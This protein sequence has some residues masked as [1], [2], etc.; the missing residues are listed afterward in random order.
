MRS[1]YQTH[2]L[3]GSLLALALLTAAACGNGEGPVSPAPIDELPRPLTAEEKAVI[4]ASNAFGF[5]LLREVHAAE[6]AP[7]VVLSPLSASLALGMTMNG[8][9]SETWEA[10]RSALRFGDLEEPAI[11]ASYHG[12]LD[13]LLD[14][15]SRVTMEI[16]NS[17]W[18]REGTPFV[19]AFFDAAREWF[20]A[21]VRELRFDDPASVDVINDWASDNTAGRIDEIIERIDPDN[22]MFLLNAVYFKGQWTVQFDPD[23]TRP[24]PFT[25]VDGSQVQVPLMHYPS[26]R[27]VRYTRTPELEAVDLGY[28]GGAF[29][30]TI[31]LP[32]AERTLAETVASLDTESWDALVA[33]LD[34][35]KIVLQ[36]PRFRVRYDELLNQPLTNMGMGIAFSGGADFT[37]LTP[38]AE[39][40]PVC[41]DF[42]RQKTFL[43]VN[44][45][46][47]EAAAVT[48]VG[49]SV[50]SAPPSMIVDRPFLLAIRERHSGTILFLGAIG[51][52]TAEESEPADDPPGQPC[53]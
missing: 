12:L 9:A 28:G 42:V 1:R 16:A 13:L 17:I 3:P 30:M 38:L 40:Y 46:G 4:A 27:R 33:A 22:I 37:R 19:P 41:I 35:A 45:E 48:A 34:S 29:A 2:P 51:D 23:D 53:G 39:S 43:E 47:T 25:R 14:L 6:T 24:A 31:V 20:D 49:V 50:T 32:A 44:E 18:A 11:N 10:M 21:E 5:D 52:P 7:N 8:A 15:D 26:D 36:V